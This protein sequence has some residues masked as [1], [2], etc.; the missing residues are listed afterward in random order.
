M[1]G[2]KMSKVT[3]PIGNM[4]QDLMGS[5]KGKAKPVIVL[6]PATFEATTK[7]VKGDYTQD[8]KWVQL[9]DLY[10]ADKITAEM[11]VLPKKGEQSPHEK[12]QNQIKDAIRL[13]FS[14][15][16]QALLNKEVKNLDDIQKGVKAH[17]IRQIGSKF[18]K[19]QEH[20]LSSDLK[21]D[22]ITIE[23][24]LALYPDKA[25]KYQDKQDKTKGAN[26]V[27]P[28][29]K[30][31]KG[32]VAYYLDL[33]IRSMQGLEKTDTNITQ[34]IKTLRLVESKYK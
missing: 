17:W 21:N 10:T 26:K 22:V 25:K 30:E 33:A 6:S 31:P 27:G 9:S 13:S 18:S 11:L 29:P 14:K 3:N 16:V 7:T 28:V 4:A 1:L 34:D 20:I 2:N 8:G 5:D 19:V 32:K 12:L 23:R 15:E 24:A